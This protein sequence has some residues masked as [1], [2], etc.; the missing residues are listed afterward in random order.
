MLQPILDSTTCSSQRHPF[1]K[2][3]LI[4]PPSIPPGASKINATW[5]PAVFC[6]SP[7]APVP[8]STFADCALLTKLLP[9]L[10]VVEDFTPD[11]PDPNFRLPFIRRHNRCLVV[12]EFRH[13]APV[14]AL[15]E[16]WTSI[17]CALQEV[18]R[19]CV[20]AKHA[21]GFAR[22][23]GLMEVGFWKVD[24]EG[25]GGG[26][27]RLGERGDGID[28]DSWEAESEVSELLSVH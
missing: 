2:P 5:P 18:L 20:L 6:Q 4:N 7:P 11:N 23:D 3:S 9:T 21:L 8:A 14:L 27:G 10:H 24:G 22:F 15:P 25:G 28:D 12:V 13:D 19:K 17:N 1:G 26:G 16:S